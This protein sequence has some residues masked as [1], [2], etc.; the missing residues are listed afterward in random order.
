MPLY[1]FLCTT[2]GAR[3]EELAFGGET[4]PCPTCGSAATERQM[5]APS[6]LK[7]GA[8]PYKPGP[9]RPLGTGRPPSCGGGCG[10]GSP[11]TP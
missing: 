1:D 8:F 5:S 4:P 11:C 7:T 3:F 6:P 9:V 10:S 2:C